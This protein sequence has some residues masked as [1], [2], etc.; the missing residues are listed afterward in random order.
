MP[1]PVGYSVTIH[2]EDTTPAGKTTTVETYRMPDKIL[3]FQKKDTYARGV[4]GGDTSGA[5]SLSKSDTK[6]CE[7]QPSIYGPNG[8]LNQPKQ[9]NE[10]TTSYGWIP[11]FAGETGGTLVWR[12]VAKVRTDFSYDGNMQLTLQTTTK[13]AVPKAGGDL[14]PTEM[15][16]K[17]YGDQGTGWIQV[18]SDSY[19]WNVKKAEWAWQANDAA[20]GSDR[21]GAIRSGGGGGGGPFVPAPVLG[22]P[23]LVFAP[24]K[25]GDPFKWVPL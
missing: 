3:L 16:I 13:S 22:T 19:V 10:E 9:K 18:S 15:T 14:V 6:T 24:P 5:L 21:P 12:I 17:R 25:L 2:T 1:I 8:P 7:W 23:P 11:K 4:V 20:M